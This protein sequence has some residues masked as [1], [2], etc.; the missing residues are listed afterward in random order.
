MLLLLVQNPQKILQVI[1]S[2]HLMSLQLNNLIVAY[3]NEV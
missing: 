2:T 3:V 1:K